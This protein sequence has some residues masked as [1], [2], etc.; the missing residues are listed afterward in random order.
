VDP[1]RL[2]SVSNQILVHSR[3]QEPPNECNPQ[4]F[5][6][7]WD[8][9][10]PRLSSIAR[11]VE[12]CEAYPNP[13]EGYADIIETKFSPGRSVALVALGEQ[14]SPVSQSLDV[15]RILK[16]KGFK[17]VCYEN[18]VCSWPLGVQ[19]QP[20]LA[21]SV[22]VLDSSAAGFVEELTQLVS[23][24][25]MSERARWQEEKKIRSIMKQVG[26]VGNSQAMISIFRWLL[27]ASV[28][29]DVPILISGETGTGKEL[30]ARAIHQLD[31]KRRNGPFVS[32]N[33][34]AINPGLAESELFGHRR[35]AFTGAD[36]E[37][38]GLIRSADRGIL[39]LDEVGELNDT[40]QTKLL[41]VIQEKKVLGVGEDQEIPVGVRFIAATNREL[42]RMV[43][44][45]KFR[46]DLFHRLGV[47]SIRIP[48]IRE[49]PED[50]KPLVQHFLSKHHDVNPAV[51]DAAGPDFIDALQRLELSGN[52]RQLENLILQAL[53]NN[54]DRTPLSLNDLPEEIWRQLSEE[55]TPS[56][57]PSGQTV[58]RKGIFDLVLKTHPADISSYFSTNQKLS[59]SAYLQHCERVFLQAALK[60]ARGNQSQTARLLGITARSV[61]SKIR[62][63]NLDH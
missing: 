16:Q 37:R 26:V 45:G 3:N 5:V 7:I 22:R 19:C 15:I 33:C 44:E 6:V 61:Y 49:R 39:F 29:S 47:L 25:L 36:R 42:D 57:A 1:R 2:C 14:P 55:A 35:G 54:V 53:V 28:L 11:A 23:Q 13:V 51:P 12:T 24:L 62:K 21:G 30:I 34:G 43:T 48:P 52:C 17:V 59:L 60:T 32:V 41:R 40:L 63:H 18:N 50:L 27:R 46:A 20:L 9:Q 31:P 56:F 8:Q 10:L 58:Y 38:K 4:L